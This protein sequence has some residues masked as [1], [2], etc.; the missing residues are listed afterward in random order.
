[1]SAGKQEN[2]SSETLRSISTPDRVESRL[3]TLEFD[4]GA[5][6]AATAELLT[7]TSMSFR[8]VAAFL[9]VFRG[10]SLTAQISVHP[11]R[12][13]HQKRAQNTTNRRCPDVCFQQGT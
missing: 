11:I 8:G 13:R 5:P 3:D 4:D 2:I 9:D 10:A 7:T 1:M 12:V 6:S